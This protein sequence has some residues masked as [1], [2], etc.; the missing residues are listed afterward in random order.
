MSDTKMK[1]RLLIL[2]PLLLFL[3][4]PLAGEKK[5]QLEKRMVYLSTNFLVDS[6]VP[7]C[8]KI[9]KKA[10]AAGYNAVAVN[11]YKFR[12]LRK[13]PKRYFA[14][15]AAFKEQA[16][17]LGIEIIPCVF[18]IGYANGILANNPNLAEGLPVKDALFVVKGIVARHVPD[19]QV[20]L[21]GGGL[22]EANQK[23]F[24]G[25]DWMDN[26]GK[27]MFLDKKIFHSGKASARMEDIATANPQHGNS[28]IVKKIK[29]RPFR[30]Y[31]LSAWAKAQNF[32]ATGSPAMAAIAL[33][34][35]NLTYMDMRVKENQDWTKY[36]IAFNSLDN[37]DVRIYVGCWGAKGGTIWWDDV[38]L[39]EIG[40]VN[41]LRRKG[42]PLVVKNEKTGMIYREGRDFEEVKDP[43]LGVIPYAG[44]YDIYHEPPKLILTSSSR[45][46][47]GERLRVSFYHPMRIHRSQYMCCMAEPEL[48]ELLRRE[49]EKINE[50][51]EPKAFF[52][53]HDEIR[54]QGW[55]ES[56]EKTGKTS[57]E[58]LAEN[59]RRCISMIK[60]INPGAEIYVW[61]DMFDPYHNAHKDYYLVKGDL[62]GSWEGLSKDVII[63][64][65]YMKIRE[66]NMPFFEK[67]GHRQVLAG[68]Y[69]SNPAKIK[70]WLDYA[71]NIEGVIGVMYTTWQSKYD[72][73]EEFAEHA[74]GKG[75]R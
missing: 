11:D 56:C 1:M 2:L 21:P 5:V 62:A 63:M 43:K 19:P 30:Y 13:M 22:E 4:L 18:P 31:Y 49:A 26:F 65:W 12:I 3:P 33:S 41:V 42:T 57:G 14:N 52:M 15:V 6:N 68:Y 36:E 60:E 59:V 46:K 38:T 32:E 50:M 44:N 10:K 64:N 47:D 8:V 34:G 75:R 29:V 45:I 16:D 20:T 70:T 27:G 17:A 54:V 39:K 55:C 37:E 28:R 74:W 9:L 35:K 51:F 69:D 7:K 23:G 71:K 25:W 72:D 24:I 73:L 40:L 53:G 48:Y 61:S 67:R 66:Q 58:I